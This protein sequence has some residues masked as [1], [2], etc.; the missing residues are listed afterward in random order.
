[1]HSSSIAAAQLAL[2]LTLSL[3]AS[4]SPRASPAQ[5]LGSSA[6]MANDFNRQIHE[7]SVRTNAYLDKCRSLWTR[8]P[9][10]PHYGAPFLFSFVWAAWQPAQRRALVEQGRTSVEQS[11]A[12]MMSQ[13]GAAP[14]DTTRMQLLLAACVPELFDEELHEELR[15]MANLLSTLWGQPAGASR[16]KDEKS[17]ARAERAAAR[18]SRP[19]HASSEMSFIDDL[20]WVWSQPT[21]QLIEHTLQELDYAVFDPP[22]DAAAVAAATASRVSPADNE[23][24]QRDLLLSLRAFWMSYFGLQVFMALSDHFATTEA[25]L[26]AQARSAAQTQSQR[27]TAQSQEKAH[28]SQGPGYSKP[29]HT[30]K[31]EDMPLPAGNASTATLT[32]MPS[33]PTSSYCAC[34]LRTSDDA[35]A[36]ATSD[37]AAASPAPLDLK[38]CARCKSAW[39]CSVDCQRKHFKQHKIECATIAAEAEASATAPAAAAAT[40]TPAAVDPPSSNA[41]TEVD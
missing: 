17:R 1:M 39:Y 12:Q 13:S 18:A 32:E 23:L 22:R 36:A 8:T 35:A 15:P 20:P 7:L 41:C 14:Q 27:Q 25:A 31:L 37:D 10:P 6:V 19:K 11:I 5:S 34:C 40:A 2:G 28:V 30:F 38:R 29:I 21:L 33:G 16:S 3:R 9:T 4:F 26:L 24:F